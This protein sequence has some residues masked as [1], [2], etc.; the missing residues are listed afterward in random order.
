M[1]A[2]A[3]ANEVRQGYRIESQTDYQA[4]LVKGNR[5]NHLL[6]LILTI[7]TAGLWGFV[8]IGVAIFGGEKREVVDIDPYGHTNIQ[9]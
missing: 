1:L 2:R 9:R 8:W 7:F 5:P 3:V 4:I 6:H